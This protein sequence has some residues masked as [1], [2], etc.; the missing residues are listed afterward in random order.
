M[1]RYSDFLRQVTFIFSL[2]LQDC[3]KFSISRETQSKIKHL[4]QIIHKVDNP[5]ADCRHLALQKRTGMAHGGDQTASC[6]V[7]SSL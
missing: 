5:Q 3:S 2:Q 1:C 6:S 7:G 4:H